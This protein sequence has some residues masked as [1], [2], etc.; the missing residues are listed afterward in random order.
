M[1]KEEREEER[2]EERKK[3]REYMIV[4]QVDVTV[5]QVYFIDNTS[6]PPN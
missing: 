5:Y 3:E 2:V 6:S 4:Y 1:A